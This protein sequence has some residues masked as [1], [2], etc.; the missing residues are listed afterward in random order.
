M[1]TF[2]SIGA[3]PGISYATAERFAQE[4]F[5]IVLSARHA[6]KAQPLADRLAAQG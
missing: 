5:R 4:G 3:G 1:K 2:V 6:A